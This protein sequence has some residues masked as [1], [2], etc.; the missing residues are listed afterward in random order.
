MSE[1]RRYKNDS[2]AEKKGKAWNRGKRT[3]ILVT[4]T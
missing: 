4:E 3:H 2:F 1:K